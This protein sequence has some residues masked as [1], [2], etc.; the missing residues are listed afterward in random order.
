MEAAKLDVPDTPTGVPD[1][2]EQHIKMLFDLQVLAF[3]AEITRI[4]TLM[5]AHELSNAVFPATNIRD[6]FHNLSHHSNNRANKDRFAELNA[7]HHTVLAYFIE[8]LKATPDG[9]GNL[10]DHSLILYG[11]GMSDGNQHNHTPLPMTLIGGASGALKGGRHIKLAK[12]TSHSNLLLTILHKVGANA[13]K[14]G[15]SSSVIGEI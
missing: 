9:D 2:F 14:I 15:D 8:K 7:Y 12:L 13:G 3:R 1:S 5:L 10:L 6:G 4:A 11:S